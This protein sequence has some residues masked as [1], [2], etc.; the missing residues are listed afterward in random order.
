MMRKSKII[1]ASVFGIVLIGGTAYLMKKRREAMKSKY[2]NCNEPDDLYQDYEDYFECGSDDKETNPEEGDIEIIVDDNDNHGIDIETS[3][4]TSDS[5][6]E[7][8]EEDTITQEPEEISTTDIVEQNNDSINDNA[9]TDIDISLICKLCEEFDVIKDK[10]ST[11]LL[12]YKI[13]EATRKAIEEDPSAHSCETE[14]DIEDMYRMYLH[15]AFEFLC[16][17]YEPTKKI[18]AEW[19]AGKKKVIDFTEKEIDEL[20]RG[21]YA[22]AL[23]ANFMQE[24]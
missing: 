12:I 19:M 8:S 21:Y 6:E 3:L 14:E 7:S 5:T 22:M 4:D 17:G 23:P 18:L 13:P 11:G 2:K 10:S 15:D 1:V 9:S 20:C 24:L 16:N